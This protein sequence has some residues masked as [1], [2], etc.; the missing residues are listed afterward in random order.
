MG[1]IKAAKFFEIQE[2]ARDQTKI[3]CDRR[4]R[5]FSKRQRKNTSSYD[6]EYRIDLCKK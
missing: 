3:S 4:Q 6:A 5:E 1:R 2:E